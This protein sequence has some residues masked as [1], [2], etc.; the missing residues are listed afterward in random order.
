MEVL[1]RLDET[2]ATLGPNVQPDRSEG[3]RFS[4]IRRVKIVANMGTSDVISSLS[5]VVA[6]AA[7]AVSYASWRASER[8]VKAAIFERRF[9]IYEDAEKFLSSWLHHGRP[10]MDQ[11]GLLMGAWSRSQF[12]C[13]PEVAT[14]LKKVRMDALDANLLEQVIAGTVE[15][16][17]GAAVQKK[18]ELIREHGDFTKLRSVFMHD[19]KI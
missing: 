8:S 18:Y 5:A 7:F 14:Y 11:L 3:N 10:D 2:A 13:R 1:D 19:L 12:V 16:D 6:I 17:H 15:G 9:S 4:G